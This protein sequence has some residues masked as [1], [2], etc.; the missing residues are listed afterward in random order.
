MFLWNPNII[1]QLSQIIAE[2]RGCTKELWQ[3]EL[4]Q[5]V[6][7]T[8]SLVIVVAGQ[9]PKLLMPVKLVVLSLFYPKTL[10]LDLNQGQGQDCC[11]RAFPV[12]PLYT[13]GKAHCSFSYRTQK[14]AATF[15][16][17]LTFSTVLSKGIIIVSLWMTISGHPDGGVN[18]SYP[19]RLLHH[20]RAFVLKAQL[21]IL[22]ALLVPFGPVSQRTDNFH[23]SCML[24]HVLRRTQEYLQWCP[25]SFSYDLDRIWKC[26]HNPISPPN[27]FSKATPE[28]LSCVEEMT[29]YNPTQ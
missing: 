7:F 5:S 15:Q 24:M 11:S 22:A 25:G 26:A 23:C 2:I 9:Q 12:L 17:G 4:G 10:G 27:Q 14:H 20:L 18:N 3:P 13:Y 28:P 8:K 19:L 21:I 1:K 6:T 29:N 16:T